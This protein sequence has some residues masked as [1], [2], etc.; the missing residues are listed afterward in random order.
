MTHASMPPSLAV[1]SKILGSL[2]PL[3]RSQMAT[4]DARRD[5]RIQRISLSLFDVSCAARGLCSLLT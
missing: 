1:R 5:A 4:L 2:H 3:Q